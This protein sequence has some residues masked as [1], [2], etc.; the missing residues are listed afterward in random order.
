[1]ATGDPIFTQLVHRLTVHVDYRLDTT[2]QHSVSGTEDVLLRLTGPGGWSRSIVLAPRTH[3]SGDHTSTD[4]TLDLPQLQSLL[5]RV[6]KLTGVVNYAGYTIAV[7]PEVHTTGSVAGQQVDPSFTQ[8]LSFQ[9]TPTQLLPGAA[10]GTSPQTAG[11]AGAGQS[12]SGLTQSQSGTV[13]SPATA[14][15]TFTLLG[16]SPQIVTLRWIALIGLLLSAGVALYAYLRKRGEPFEETFRIQSQYG[17]MIVPIVGGEDLGWPPVDV[18]NIKALV[19]LAESGQRLILHNRAN[20]VDTYMLN[21]EGTVY[22]YQVK[23]SNV[24]WREWSETA[25]EADAAATEVSAAA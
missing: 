14:P 21:E 1:V 8:G 3:F 20:N 25:T 5:G 16:V 19:K 24:V 2:A 22:R 17:H 18:P 23:P 11:G 7:V 9:L 15:N 10:S 13:S 12:N 4:V 6:A